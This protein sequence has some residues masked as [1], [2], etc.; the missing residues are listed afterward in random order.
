MPLLRTMARVRGLVPAETAISLEI[1]GEGPDRARLERFV[2]AHQMGGWVRLPGRVSR[3]ELRE[4]YAAADIYVAPAPLESF[5]IAALEA[6]TVGLPVVGR[7][8]SGLAEFVKDGLNGYLAADDAAMAGSIA[9]LVSDN[10]LRGSM[11][12]FNRDNAPEQSWGR[13]LDG[14]EGEYRRAIALAALSKG[15]R[16]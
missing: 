12:A 16:S 6:R 1:L 4:T 11:T 8:G 5:G 9:R 14:A 13:I 15:A 7:L 3:D 2:T 10:A